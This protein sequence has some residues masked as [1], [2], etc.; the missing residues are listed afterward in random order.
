MNKNGLRKADVI[1]RFAFRAVARLDELFLDKENV[2]CMKLT[3]I[4]QLGSWAG[5]GLSGATRE[6]RKRVRYRQKRKFNGFNHDV[7]NSKMLIHQKDRRIPFCFFPKDNR[8]TERV[9]S[10]DWELSRG[11]WPLR[12]LSSEGSERCGFSPEG[13]RVRRGP[14]ATGTAIQ[15]HFYCRI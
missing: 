3:D 1:F 8:E 15:T 13:E 2:P 10:Q 7:W 9:T 11:T 14:P 12:F 4:A 5:T 6:K